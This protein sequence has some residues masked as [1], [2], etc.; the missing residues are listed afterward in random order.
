MRHP[1]RKHKGHRGPRATP[2]K[3]R[4]NGRLIRRGWTYHV[5][6]MKTLDSVEVVFWEGEV[7]G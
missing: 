2:W 1:R 5:R 7:R 4:L 3:F 6:L